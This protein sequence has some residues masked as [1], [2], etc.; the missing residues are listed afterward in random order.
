MNKE[1]RIVREDNRLIE[2]REEIRLL[3]EENARLEKK[4]KFQLQ[5][6]GRAPVLEDIKLREQVDSLTEELNNIRANGS[7]SFPLEN[8]T[9]LEFKTVTFPLKPGK[10]VYSSH[11][12]I[13][14]NTLIFDNMK[15]SSGEPDK[16]GVE[17]FEGD[18]VKFY[19]KGEWVTCEIVFYKACFC[20]KWSDGYINH[21]PIDGKNLEVIT[22]Q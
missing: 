13:S 6:I 4:I 15:R 21:Y 1:E 11:I 17:I 12:V 9:M 10:D 20:L 2:L 19:F 16:N 3:K 22:S 18:K 5:V 14:C 8:N 7:Q